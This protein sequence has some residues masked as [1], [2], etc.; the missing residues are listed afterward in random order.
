MESGSRQSITI[1]HVRH[2]LLALTSLAFS[3]ISATSNTLYTF[4]KRKA[5][6]LTERNYTCNHTY[7]CICI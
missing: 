3:E 2:N 7:V 5:P 4:K 1:R 6:H